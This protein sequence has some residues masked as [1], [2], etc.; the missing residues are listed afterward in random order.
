MDVWVG[1]TAV[2]DELLLASLPHM[3]RLRRLDLTKCMKITSAVLG[4]AV[5]SPSLTWLNVSHCTRVGAED[6]AQCRRELEKHGRQLE[7]VMATIFF[8]RRP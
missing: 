6:I 7:V 8:T 1:V 2:T 4:A 5:A 3:P